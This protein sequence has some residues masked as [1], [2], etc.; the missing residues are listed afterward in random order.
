[1]NM[2]VLFKALSKKIQHVFFVALMLF[3]H[4]ML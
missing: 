4:Y 3:S 1:M 2:C